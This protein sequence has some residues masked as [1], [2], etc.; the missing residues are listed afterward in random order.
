MQQFSLEIT[1]WIFAYLDPMDLLH[2][3]LVDT[4]T[5]QLLQTHPV[6]E[7]HA[8]NELVQK[9]ASD[10]HWTVCKAAMFYIKLRE[11]VS[12][13]YY[14]PGLSLIH[15]HG[16]ND[17]VVIITEIYDDRER[18]GHMIGDCVV[19]LRAVPAIECRTDTS[20]KHQYFCANFEPN[21]LYMDD[22]R[23]P[24]HVEDLLSRGY[25]YTKIGVRIY[26][27]YDEDTG[28]FAEGMYKLFRYGIV[29]AECLLEQEN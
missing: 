24:K 1:C 13:L 14:A 2:L 21:V 10:K 11:R 7:K 5:H 25:V 17:P 26:D 15:D 22:V 19:M 16:Y 6:W 9:K 12:W 8:S 29:V 20:R 18:F 23:G 28:C 4:Y 3:R 27:L